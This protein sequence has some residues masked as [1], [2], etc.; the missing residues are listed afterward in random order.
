LSHAREHLGKKSGELESGAFAVVD[1]ETTGLDPVSNEIIE[2]GAIKISGGEVKDIFNKLI[3]PTAQ[4]SPE[5][6][7]L[8]GITQDMVADSPPIKDVLPGFLNFIGDCTLIAH[9]V[10]FDI[11]FLK[12]SIQKW[13]KASLDN[14]TIC[15]L[16]LSRAILPNLGNHKLHT[17]A[18]Y[19]K[20]E[21]SGRHRAIG[22]AEATLQVWKELAKKLK[23]KNINTRADITKFLGASLTETPF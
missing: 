9:N 1:I 20:I 23:A 15:T 7:N 8:T 5:I 13:L 12:V 16:L 17:V 3:R 21:I 10:D 19:F 6:T 22:D 4:I 18:R 2:I 11:P 14:P